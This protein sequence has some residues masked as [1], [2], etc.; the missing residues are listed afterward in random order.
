MEHID[1]F[2]LQSKNLLKDYKTRSFDEKESCYIYTPKHWDIPLILS[3]FGY[4]DEKDNFSFTLMNA[5]HVISKLAGFSKWADLINANESEL[6]YAHRQLDKSFY[7]IGNDKLLPAPQNLY[8][9]IIPDI[10]VMGIRV[11]FSFDAVEY[12]ES[13]MIYASDEQDVSTAK[14]LAEGMF[15]PIKYIYR[16]N[17]QPH[18]FYWVRAFDGDE[19]GAWS[20]IAIRNR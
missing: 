3:D 5:Q 12:A 2:K 7:K 14:S 13:Y 8:A 17:R 6:S 10:N 11:E 4:P 15:S 19:Y 9:M 20:S 1:Y 18:K 16:G